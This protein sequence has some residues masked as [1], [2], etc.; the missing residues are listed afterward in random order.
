MT[1]RPTPSRAVDTEFVREATQLKETAEALAKTASGPMSDP[2]TLWRACDRLGPVAKA[3]GR[4]FAA[5][6]DHINKAAERGL[7]RPDHD[8]IDVAAASSDAFHAFAQAERLSRELAEAVTDADAATAG[9]APRDNKTDQ[10]PPMANTND[11][12]DA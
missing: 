9:F 3:L 12:E 4:T 5:L 6:Q 11:A 1:D 2:H 10:H 8:D 7:L